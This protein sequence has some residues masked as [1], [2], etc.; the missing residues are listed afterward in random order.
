VLTFD[1]GG[2]IVT[3]NA[4]RP[5]AHPRWALPPAARV[6]EYDELACAGTSVY[7]DAPGHLFNE[8]LPRLIHLDTVLPTH[9]PLLWPPGALP[10]RLLDSLRANGL[11]SAERDFVATA[12]GGASVYRARRLYFYASDYPSGHTPL[13]LATSQRVLAARLQA[14]AER[15]A[16]A[17]AAAGGP[18]PDLPLDHGGIVLLLRNGGEARE[19]VNAPALLDA[20]RAAHPGVRVDAFVPGAPGRSY[21][22]AAARVL[23]ARVVIGPHGANLNNFVATRA[24]AWIVE[25]GYADNDNPLPSDYFCQ[26]RNLGLRYWLSMADAGSYGSGIVANIDDVLEITRRAYAGGE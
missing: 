18:P 24:G 12:L 5:H 17:A 14:L 11:I 13:I 9:I 4:H 15:G 2:K 20:L 10:A 25:L 21:V 26:A 1:A 16:A 7:P 23:G 8:I 3:Y 6:I 22:E 19:V